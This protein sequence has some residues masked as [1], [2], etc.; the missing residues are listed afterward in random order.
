MYNKPS[1]NVIEH[2]SRLLKY[3][4]TTLTF[5]N[6][7]VQ[8]QWGLSDCG[9]F[10]SA[11]A[12]DLCHGLDPVN[13]KYDQTAMHQHYVH[14]LGTN[15]MVPF[16]NTNKRVP[17]QM[18]CIKTLVDIHCVCRLPNDHQPYVRCFFCQEWY[19]PT[20]VKIP[21]NVINSKRK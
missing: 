20:C 21:S 10:A 9:L 8:K 19:H 12:T 2:S 6:E 17:C 3:G 4:G 14:C 13:E 16:P 18:T 1:R 5:V 7:K 15:A 11:F